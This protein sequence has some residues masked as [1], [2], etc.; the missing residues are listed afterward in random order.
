MIFRGIF[1]DWRYRNAFRFGRAEHT[2]SRLLGIFLIIVAV[3][4]LLKKDLLNVHEMRYIIWVSTILW[5]IY[6]VCHKMEKA[7]FPK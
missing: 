2:V 7:L 4:L 1:D 3:L 6:W 5:L